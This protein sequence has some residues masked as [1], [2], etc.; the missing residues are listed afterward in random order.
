M[1]HL[2]NVLRI[3]LVQ[4]DGQVTAG[5]GRWTGYC[6][7]RKMDRLWLVKLLVQEDGQVTAGSGRWTGYCWIRKMDRLLLVQEDGQVTDG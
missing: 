3:T 6:W 7:F 1:A 4:E 2:N 5:S